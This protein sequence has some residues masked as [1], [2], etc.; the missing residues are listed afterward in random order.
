MS[1]FNKGHLENKYCTINSVNGVNRCVALQA[2]YGR[3]KHQRKVPELLENSR[4]EFADPPQR[5]GTP[6]NSEK[7]FDVKQHFKTNILCVGIQCFYFFIR[8]VS[9]ERVK[10]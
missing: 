6:K 10:R 3:N 2:V 1:R 9:G 5:G 7:Y 8:G 4:K